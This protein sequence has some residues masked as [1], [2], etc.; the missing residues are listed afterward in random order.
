MNIDPAAD[1]MIVDEYMDSEDDI[2]SDEVL[3]TMVEDDEMSA[4]DAGFMQGYN[5]G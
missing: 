1:I 4:E 2:Y 3:E 5:A